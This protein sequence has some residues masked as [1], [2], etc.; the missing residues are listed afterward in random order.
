MLSRVMSAWIVLGLIVAVAASPFAN[1]AMAQEKEKAP[2]IVKEIKGDDGFKRNRWDSVKLKLES[3]EGKPFSRET[4]EG[5]LKKLTAMGQFASVDYEVEETSPGNVVLTFKA[6]EY[7][8]ID[9]VRF[10]GLKSV[11]KKDLDTAGLRIDA[12]SMLN[13]Y[14]LKLDR[15]VIRETYLSKGYYFVDVGEEVVTTDAGKTLQW[16]VREGP[17]VSVESIQFSGNASVK[18]ADLYEVMKTKE[19]GFFSS[20]PFIEKDLREDVERIK[21]HYMMNGWLDVYK[22]SQKKVFVED[23]RFNGGLTKASIRIHINEGRRFTIGNVTVVGN[24]LFTEAEIREWLKSKSGEFYAEA[25]ARKDASTIEEKY[26]ERAYILAEVEARPVFHV[27]SERIDLVYDIKENEKVKVGKLIIQGNTKT[28]DDVIRREIRVYPGE[29][30]NQKELTR[31]V[32]RLYGKHWFEYGKIFV[33]R[34]EGDEPSTRDIVIDVTEAPTGSARLAGGYSSSYGVI[35]MFEITQKNFD[36]G[37]L[38]KSFEELVDGTGFAGGGQTLRLTFMPGARRTRYSLSFRE[39]Y[40]FG[41]DVGFSFTAMNMETVRRTYDETKRGITL[42]LDKRWEELKIGLDYRYNNIKIN[43][44]T[45]AAPQSIREL[46]GDNN[47]VSLAPSI[48]Y[49]TRNY[50]SGLY[51]NMGKNIELVYEYAGGILPGDFNYEK[52]TLKMATYHTVFTTEENRHH[53][54]SLEATGGIAH[55][56]AGSD[57]V[58]IF[59]RFF[60]GGRNTIRGF[61]FRGIG[62]KDNNEPIG[63]KALVA[64]SLEYTFPLYTDLL[65]GAFFYD[66]ANLSDR[67]SNLELNEFRMSY[68]VGVRF[69]I[70]E[71]GNIPLSLDFGFPVS[72]EDGDDRQT[73]LFDIGYFY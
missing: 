38:P 11:D 3:R 27:G 20:S 43:N 69:V 10:N 63:G 39:P 12:G 7:D 31:S 9:A 17:Y 35:G 41:Q 1:S 72:K 18:A 44:L 2:R 25:V 42:G 40:L 34:V 6:V 15:E 68:G 19:N 56:L 13:P 16:N 71:L 8:F 65:R 67:P 22:D 58:P 36:L 46:E 5:D 50:E 33:S 57:N 28:R 45:G 30:Y 24:K 61:D 70:R 49:D 37:D 53:V 73:V 51:P 26:G 14:L 55:E 59:E 48:Q 21:H 52:T 4:V 62:P 32:N 64:A 29:D 54:I 23:L 66:W 60:A 47:I